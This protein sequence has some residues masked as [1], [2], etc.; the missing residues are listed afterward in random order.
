MTDANQVR[1]NELARRA[2]S[3]KQRPLSTFCLASRCGEKTHSSSIPVDVAE[4][5]R[6]TIQGQAEA[7]SVA[8]T[9]LQAESK[10]GTQLLEAPAR[11]LPRRQSP[12]L[13]YVAICSACCPPAPA[14][15]LQS[16]PHR[17]Q[18]RFLRRL[19]PP[20]RLQ[21]PLP[22]RSTCAKPAPP[23]SPPAAPTQHR[24]LRRQQSLWLLRKPQAAN[25]FRTQP[26]P[27][28]PHGQPL[29][30]A[31]TKCSQRFAHTT[32]TSS[33]QQRPGQPGLNGPQ[34]LPGAPWYTTATSFATGQP[35]VRFQ[36]VIAVRCQPAIVVASFR[37]STQWPRPGQPMRPHRADKVAK[38]VLIL[39]PS[40]LVD[41]VVQ[42]VRRIV[43]VWRRPG[44]VPSG[45][46]P[47]RVSLV[48]PGM[49]PAPPPDRMPSKA[50]PQA[51]LHSQAHA[52]S[53]SHSDK[54]EM[55]GERKLHPTRQRP[56]AGDRRA[57]AII[58]PPEPR[59]ARHHI[60]GRH[61]HFA[62]RRKTRRARE[63]PSESSPRQG[64]FASINQALDSPTAT[65]L[66]EAFN[67]VVTVVSFET[68]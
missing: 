52:A 62:T 30:P 44:A 57:A 28:A 68:R 29:R 26:V 19:K 54:R 12:P 55:E 25:A 20:P 6:R 45:T 63:R 37:R 14:P 64:N 9:P 34:P 50:E 59:F 53:A 41:K 66:A 58:G 2:R 32:S 49:L 36:R 1:I 11:N 21:R 17:H 61:H 56:G 47:G 60:T 38:V 40:G 23:T 5:V 16:P 27:A 13:L 7:E 46:R 67:G 48:D 39:R 65:Q 42:V 35:P 43:L 22:S 3:Q 33:G 4:K 10:P 15:A 24:R 18:L 51:A 31:Y 8:E